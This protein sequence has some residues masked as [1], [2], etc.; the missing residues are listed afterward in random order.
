MSPPVP[1]LSRVT[2]PVNWEETFCGGF[3]GFGEGPQ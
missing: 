1:F 2:D 3:A